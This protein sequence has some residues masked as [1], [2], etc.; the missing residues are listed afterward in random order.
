MHAFKWRK[1]PFGQTTAIATPQN[2]KNADKVL[3]IPDATQKHK[4]YNKF[5]G[6]G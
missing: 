4:K 3:I 1:N 2:L 6:L 5:V